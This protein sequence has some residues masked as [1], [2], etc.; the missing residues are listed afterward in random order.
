MFYFR[1]PS[2]SKDDKNDL[3]RVVPD[4]INDQDYGSV[5]QPKTALGKHCPKFLLVSTE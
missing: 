1:K 5:F 2:Q 4:R 3:N